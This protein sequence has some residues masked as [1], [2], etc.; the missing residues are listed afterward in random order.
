MTDR[1]E[2][3]SW[4][5]SIQ[6]NLPMGNGPPCI[7]AIEAAAHALIFPPPCSHLKVQG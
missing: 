3:S 4:T 6:L 2:E 1:D 7:S 5:A